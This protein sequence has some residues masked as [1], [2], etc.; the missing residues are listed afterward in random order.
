MK[1]ELEALFAS[2]DTETLL[3]EVLL[4]GYETQQ[5]YEKYGDAFVP[6]KPLAP[7]CTALVKVSNDE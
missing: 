6:L 5:D 3:K 2:L 4:D 1:T 7:T